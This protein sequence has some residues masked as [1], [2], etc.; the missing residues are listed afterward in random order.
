M[1]TPWRRRDGEVFGYLE[2][3]EEVEH[4]IDEIRD[5]LTV[6]LA[7]LGKQENPRPEQW[8]RGLA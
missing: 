2:I 5:S 4:L 1:V 3:G 7:V 6:D 8:R